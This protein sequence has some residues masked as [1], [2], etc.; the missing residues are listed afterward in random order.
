MRRIFLC[1]IFLLAFSLTG[2]TAADQYPSK[3]IR[4]ITPFSAGGNTDIVA[5]LLAQSLTQSLGQNVVVYNRPGAGGSLGTTLVAQARPDG[6]TLLLA[7]SS[8]HGINSAVYPDL[9]YDALKDFAP[10]TTVAS[11][12]YALVV[13]TASAIKTVDDLLK[14]NAKQ[15]LHYA[16]NGAGTT[17]DLASALLG[18]RAGTKFIQVPYKG[19][20]PAEADLMGGRVD[21]LMDNTTDR[22]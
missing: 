10:V 7:T 12:E 15:T 14:A 3:P 16:S 20:A 17:S 9:K 13:P 4:L 2:A 8:T 5:R 18:L 21:F 11:S 19:S 1:A 22:T 6:Y